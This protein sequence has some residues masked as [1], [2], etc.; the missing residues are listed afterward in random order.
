MTR[1]DLLTALPAWFASG[2]LKNRL[3][4]RVAYRTESDLGTVPPALHDYLKGNIAPYLSTLGFASQVLDN[5]SAKGGP[6]LVARRIENPARPTVLIYAHGDVVNGQ[7]TRWRDGLSPWSLVEEGDR[8]YGRGTADNKGQHTVTLAALERVIAAKNGVLGYNVTVLMETGE[9]AG[10]PGLAAFC[11]AHAEL[12]KADVMLSSDG[13]RIHAQKPTLFLGCRGTI[14]F[15]LKVHSRDKA[16]HSGNWGGVLENPAIR[17]THALA[18]LVDAKGKLLVAGLRAPD[19]SAEVRAALKNVPMGSDADDPEIDPLWGEAQLSPAERLMACNTLE[20][21]AL[22]SGNADRPVNAIPPAATAHCQLRFVVGTD[23]DN[24]LS[25]VQTHLAAHGFKDVA[26]HITAAGA[27]SRLELSS[28]W[29]AWA[30]QSMQASSGKNTTI[31][32]NL[33]GSLPN[34]VF[35]DI[36]GLPTLWVPHSY[37]GCNQHAPNEHL[38]QSVAL[39][40]LVLMAGLFWDLSPSS[41][42]SDSALK[43]PVAWL[44]S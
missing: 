42:V 34:D 1:N 18:T 22:G 17:L 30:A 3:A 40:G 14:N 23:A 15:S 21:L 11:Q 6:V 31:L 25:H 27:A 43:P 16:Y 26:V 28:P 13:P 38:L 39:E 32:P 8:W 24:L 35:A 36:L 19:V 33:A 41:P 12:L 44:K 2:E 37:P 5:P 20:I 29:V 10:S 7:D 9:E 4:Q